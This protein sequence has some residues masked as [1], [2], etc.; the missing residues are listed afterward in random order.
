MYYN[1]EKGHAQSTCVT[2]VKMEHHVRVH[3]W[4]SHTH[5]RRYHEKVPDDTAENKVQLRHY[6]EHQGVR[7][8]NPGK[9][10]L[11]EEAT[12]VF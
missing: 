12:R 4:A 9:T 5:D 2:C 3:G 1:G 10:T 8:A 6:V 11:S 7:Q